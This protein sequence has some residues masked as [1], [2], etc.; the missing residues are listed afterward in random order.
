MEQIGKDSISQ[1]ALAIKGKEKDIDEN[2]SGAKA[3]K[4]WR[5]HETFFINRRGKTVGKTSGVKDWA[6][7]SMKDLIQSF[8]TS[9][10][11]LPLLF[12]R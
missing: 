3:Y 8:L 12:Q 11:K 1:S 9:L 7:K 2:G 4:I 6:S 5:Y 10:T